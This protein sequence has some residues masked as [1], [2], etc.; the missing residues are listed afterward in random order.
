MTAAC[1]VK[2]IDCILRENQSLCVRHILSSE[3]KPQFGDIHV[4]PEIDEV[5]G[6]PR[7][8]KDELLTES[9][10]K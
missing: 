10:R 8:I 1:Y 4:P 9:P 2:P 7:Y 3:R 5:D 6:C